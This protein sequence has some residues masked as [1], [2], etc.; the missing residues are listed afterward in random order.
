MARLVQ[1]PT[2]NNQ[3]STTRIIFKQ[4]VGKLDHT[5]S[6]QANHQD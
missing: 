2:T 1:Q 6:N 5:K 3:Q 4:V